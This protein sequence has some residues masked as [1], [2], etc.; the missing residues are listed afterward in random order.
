MQELVVNRMRSIVV[1]AGLVAAAAVA[2]P[3]AVANAA[4]P[5]SSTTCSSPTAVTVA[6]SAGLTQALAAARPGSM[7][8]LAPG[9]YTGTF[10]LRGAGT[11]TRPI[12]LCG[13]R[14]AVLTAGVT[15][16]GYTLHLDG[17]SYWQVSGFTVRGGLKG[18]MADNAQANRIEGLLIDGVGDEALHLRRG[19]SDN[20]V[21]GN[22]IQ[23]AGLRTPA[24]GEGVY[25]GS[26]QSNWCE[27]TACAPDRSDRNT[28]ELNDISATTAEAVDV[29]EGTTGG[30][31]RKNKINGTGM[32]AADSWV[33]VKGNGWTISE[34]TGTASPVDGFQLH[35][36]LEGWALDNV[37]T[38]NN[39]TVDGTGYGFLI[40]TNKDR[41]QVTC[42]NKVFRAAKGYANAACR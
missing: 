40:T 15:D 39:S 25:V 10:V 35:K 20:L 7:I 19:S 36:V 23:R 41:N 38:G 30:T 8:K 3:A 2:I 13:P 16:R 26:A 12:A 31:L 34:N 4:T 22:T 28:I 14:T 29:K 33:D 11:A 6:T 32:T 21:R 1:A 27:L 42:T 17:A 37:F 5:P 24:I 18:V 9:T